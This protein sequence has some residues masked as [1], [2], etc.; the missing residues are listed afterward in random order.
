[1][2]AQLTNLISFCNYCFGRHLFLEEG[3]GQLF[4][5]FMNQAQ[6]K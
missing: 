1:M 4:A 3:L 2:G 6:C 5:L